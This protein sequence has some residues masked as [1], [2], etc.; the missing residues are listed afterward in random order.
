[1]DDPTVQLAFFV[2][3]I[4][5]SV[6]STVAIFSI[7]LTPKLKAMPVDA[8]VLLL[9][10]VQST[11][12]IG[13]GF[14][15]PGVVSSEAPE[16]FILSAGFGDIAAAILALAAMYALHTRRPGALRLAWIANL[17]GFIDLVMAF[18]FG[19]TMG[20][21]PGQLQ[22]MFLVVTWYVPIL[23]VAHVTS[24]R[25]LLAARAE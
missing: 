13:A 8:A 3:N 9:L 18:A 12:A 23:M 4:M 7:W 2:G 14:L 21:E 24:F 19:I 5:L 11:R 17:F 6:A 25:L 15:V 22:S 16:E 1:M 20:L 10:T